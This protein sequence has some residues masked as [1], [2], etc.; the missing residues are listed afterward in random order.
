LLLAGNFDCHHTIKLGIAG[1]PNATESAHA[2][3]LNQLE[4][5]QLTRRWAMVRGRGVTPHQAEIAAARR[6][7]QL[8]R[9]ILLDD[10]NRILAVRTADVH[11]EQ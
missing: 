6:T 1:L 2:E 10:L 11:G 4:V 7:A 3:L 5:A 8:V 9:Q